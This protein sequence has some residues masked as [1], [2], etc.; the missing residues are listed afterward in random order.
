M[1]KRIFAFFNHTVFKRLCAAVFLLAM[2]SALDVFVETSLNDDIHFPDGVQ[3]VLGGVLSLLLVFRTNSA[4][5]RWWE[6]RK[7]WGQ[8]VNDSRNL[9]LKVR[10]LVHIPPAERR[11][12]GEII[13]AF[14]HSLRDHLRGRR[15]PHGPEGVNHVPLYLARVMFDKIN[16]WRQSNAID[17]WTQQVLDRHVAAWMDIAGACERIRNTPLPLSHRALIPQILLCYMLVL[18]ISLPDNL[19]T[20]LVTC[21]VGYFMLGLEFIAEELEEPFGHDSD[22]LP[23]EQFCANIDRSVQEALS[24]EDPTPSDSSKSAELP[25]AAGPA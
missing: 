23:L 16:G 7:Q 20:I 21:T 15:S 4:Y 12:T 24:F 6:A 25:A 1:L 2:Y 10:S 18:P 19:W 17:G 11:R 13:M 14:P 8:L 9:A 5:D 3:A 22:D